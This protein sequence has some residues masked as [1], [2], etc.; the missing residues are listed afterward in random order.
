M[1]VP[2]GEGV[3]WVANV[4]SRRTNEFTL[5]YASAD[6]Q[7]TSVLSRWITSEAPCS[8]Q[9]SWTSDRIC[10]ESAIDGRVAFDAVHPWVGGDFNPLL[11]DSNAGLDQCSYG[12]SSVVMC[13]CKC[14][15][16]WACDGFNQSFL[17]IEFPSME[18]CEKQ[19]FSPTQVRIWCLC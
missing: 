15:P 6:R 8:A 13:P 10:V 2:T 5:Y 3:A 17:S 12:S 9:P 1:Q 16:N 18:A 4:A 19:I 11:P 14:S 7:P